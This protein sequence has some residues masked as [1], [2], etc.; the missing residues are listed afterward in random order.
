[1]FPGLILTFDTTSEDVMKEKPRDSEEILSKNIIVLLFIFGL[2][3]SISM[4]VVYWITMSGIYP[5]FPENV[6]FGNLNHTYLINCS[7]EITYIYHMS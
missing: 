6:E 7:V 3:L 5:V 4:V 1:M 2:L